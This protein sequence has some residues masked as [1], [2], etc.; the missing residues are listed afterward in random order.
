MGEVSNRTRWIGKVM[1]SI[2][3]R[4]RVTACI[5]L[6]LMVATFI[7]CVASNSITALAATTVSITKS[8]GWLETAYVE[9]TPVAGATGYNVYYKPENASDAQYAKIDA[10]L[11]R[12]YSSRYRADVLGLTAGNYVL[13]VVPTENDV[14]VA[15]AAA[16]TQ[17]LTVKAHTREGFAFSAQSPMGTGSGGYNDNGT[18]PSG[19]QIIY[20]TPSTANTVTLTVITNN[21]GATTACTGLV[22]ILAARQKGYD[23][24]PLIIRLIGKVKG[25][26]ISGLNSSGYIQVKG[27]YNVTL[28]GI[29][30]DATV[31]EWGILVREAHNV[32]IRNLGIML[33]PDD[34]I[35][36]DTG[37]QNI[38][39]HNNDIFY[40]ST[41]GDSDQAKGDGSCDVKGFSDYVTVSYNHFW[42]SGKCSLCGMGD[43]KEFHVTYHHN[44][45]DHSDSRHPRIRFGTVH[46]YNNY[47]DGVSKYG[48]GNTTSGSA[49]VEANYFRHCKYPMLI[50]LQ[51]SDIYNS[52]TGAY[53]TKLGTFS[54]EPGGMNKAFNN[55]IEGATRLIYA[56]GDNGDATQFDAYLATTRD[57]QVS[58]TYKTLNGG[59]AYN[60]FDTAST[61]YSYTPDSPEAAKAIVT[62]YAGRVNGGDFKWTFTEADDTS[63]DVNTALKEKIKS[64]QPDQSIPAPAAPTNLTATADNAQVTLSWTASSGAVCYN[65]K[66]ATTA[67][68]PYTTVKS[69]LVATGY[70]DTGLT[71]GTKYYYVVTAMNS[72]GGESENSLEVNATPTPPA[73]PATPANFT[74]TAGDA[75][76]TLSWTASTGATSYNVKRATTSGGPYTTVKTGLTA[77]SYTDTGLTNGTT[78]YYVVSAVN[79]GGESPNSAEASAKPV[80]S[81]PAVPANLAITVGDKQ[82]GLSWTA[83]KGAVSYNVKRATT[84][85]GSYTTVKT[86]LTT[87]NYTDTGLNNG[88]KYYYVVSGVNAIGEGAN[89]AEVSATPRAILLSN[90]VVNDT[91]YATYWSIQSNIQVGSIIFG[92]RASGGKIYKIK[93][94]PS[95]YVGCDWISTACDSK[96]YTG[97]TLA[98]FTVNTAAIVY[99]A[100]DD[101]VTTKPSWLSSWTDTGDN[102]TDDES[103]SVTFSLYSKTFGSGDQVTLGPQSYSGSCTGY[104]VLAKLNNTLP[105]ISINDVTVTEGNSGTTNAVFTV[106]LSKAFAEAVTV[107]YATVDG[108]ATTANN[109]YVAA[110]GTITFNSGE[111]SKTISVIVNGDTEKEEDE[112]FYVDLSNASSNAT[113]TTSRGTGTILDDDRV[114]AATP[115][116]SLAGGN[117][118]TPQTVTISCATDGAK[119]Y[120]TSDG[121]EPS[122][123]A[124]LY[125][126]DP[127]VVGST[128]TLKAKAFLNGWRP[129]ATASVSYTILGTIV[130]N[131]PGNNQSE[132][133]PAVLKTAQGYRNDQSVK[134]NGATLL[135]SK[136]NSGRISDLWLYYPNI[137]GSGTGQIPAN[138]KIVQAKLV[139][140]VKNIT[141]NLYASHGFK[142][143]TITDPDGYGAP[144]FGADGVRNGLD[145]YYRDHRA[146][147]NLPWKNNAADITG[148]LNENSAADSFGFVPA[149]FQAQ[150]ESQIQ[151][152][153]TSSVQAWLG[154]QSNQGWFLTIDNSEGWQSGDSIEFY[155]LAE[156]DAAKRPMLQINYLTQGSVASQDPVTNLTAVSGDKQV[157]LSWTPPA[158]SNGVKI[159]RKAG[160]VPFD[161]L[162]GTLVYD[163]PAS[164]V[165]DQ[166]LTNGTTYYYS[167]FAYDSL[168][169]YSNKVW[170]NAVPTVGGGQPATPSNLTVVIS[171]QNLQFTWANNTVN[172]NWYVLEQRENG[173]DWVVVAA[174]EGSLTAYA[175]VLDAPG[176]ELKPNTAYQYRI[177]AVNAYGSSDYATSATVTTPD[178]P[179]A[180]V[181]LAWKIVSSGRVTLTWTDRA[182]NETGYRIEVLNAANYEVL[183]RVNLASNADAYSVTGLT[184]SVSY[185][186]KVVV[187]NGTGEAAV[188]T[189]PITTTIDPKT[190]F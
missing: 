83:S 69:G 42:D 88:T 153:V 20:I 24:T 29:G 87:T 116:F 100:V 112:L 73:A 41:G 177:K 172:A 47:F 97:T 96:N 180:P 134:Y 11:I 151:L 95:A 127:I 21:K 86:G 90:L 77:T 14:E 126:G 55:K 7:A 92:D 157:A 169:N 158:V 58:S 178:F 98:T 154:G 129:S 65:V 185:I 132:N 17:A 135:L 40:G 64:Y 142:I 101:R 62:T 82:L 144:C 31:Y 103:P 173:G 16:I 25:S 187:L 189:E 161:S 34:G 22:N 159:V 44:W 149:L 168:R 36:L 117:Y 128:M 152:D 156:T 60:N 107:N 171:G 53:D 121:T 51:G 8:G 166:G 148:L 6:S 5:A 190:G 146:G 76:V 35:S 75:E 170:T 61:M 70:V 45:F 72:T 113:V 160:S 114:P 181:D 137:S 184:P 19:A 115:T 145:F 32:E 18:V 56:N 1:R 110:A 186:I 54:S 120:Y 78:Y 125:H 118:N 102:I 138:A 9:W 136:G 130:T 66:R 176:L 57:E 85:G 2:P 63:Y 38:W 106:S 179:M 162:D 71:N 109:D 79:A 39:V 26:D 27:C 59:N 67:G 108:T 167:V 15:A 147:K 13:K 182:T 155:G 143:Y 80:L 28:E 133:S 30:E 91:S 99:V 43:S 119:I 46:I 122:E 12:Q 94:L 150:G 105:S 164:N 111:T 139:L 50:S 4:A 48:V 52:D 141:G 131:Q 74:A 123:T 174:P 84:S 89:S 104:F 23:K 183:W 175:T 93:T 10:P 165:T 163:G 68:G 188:W 33:F 140:T 124:A 3:R 49:F 37:N 81:L